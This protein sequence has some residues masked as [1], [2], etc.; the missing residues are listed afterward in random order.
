MDSILNIEDAD[1]LSQSLKSITIEDNQPKVRAKIHNC[2]FQSNANKPRQGSPSLRAQNKR[3]A[4]KESDRPRKRRRVEKPRRSPRFVSKPKVINL[5]TPPQN[6]PKRRHISFLDSNSDSDDIEIVPQKRQKRSVCGS[7]HSKPKPNF[8]RKP[9]PRIE[10]IPPASQPSRPTRPLKEEPWVPRPSMP[11]QE[12]PSA[13]LPPRPQQE[14][15]SAPPKANESAADFEFAKKMQEEEDARLARQLA[16]IGEHQMRAVP[17]AHRRRSPRHN[18]NNPYRSRDYRDLRREQEEADALAARR[19]FQEQERQFQRQYHHHHN[20]EPRP[21]DSYSMYF[22]PAQFFQQLR[23][24]LSAGRMRLNNIPDFDNMSYE[25]ICDWESQQ[26]KV[27][28]GARPDEIAG[29]P[30]TKCSEKIA[31]DGEQCPICM[32]KYQVGEDIKILPCT[33]LFHPQC[34]DK[35]FEGS[36]KCPVCKHDIR[37]GN[38]GE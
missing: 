24:R 5:M 1:S 35:W 31:K 8:K 30:I 38:G 13:P 2:P 15:V 10:P 21:G 23:D 37:N 18:N 20:P 28:V 9:K 32:E 22:N 34:I 27:N 29:L 16:G 12:Q 11:V 26:G 17:I 33:H 25:E 19:L 7:R 6:P 14:E 36:R 3:K 4:K